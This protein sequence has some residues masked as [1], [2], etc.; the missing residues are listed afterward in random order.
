MLEEAQQNDG[1]QVHG[2]GVKDAKPQTKVGQ[3]MEENRWMPPREIQDVG[4]TKLGIT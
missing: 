2:V 3:E 1:P 4:S